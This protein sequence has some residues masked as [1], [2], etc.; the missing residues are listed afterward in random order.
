MEYI[1]HRCKLCAMLLREE[2]K[3]KREEGRI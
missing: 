1:T 2:I 3:E